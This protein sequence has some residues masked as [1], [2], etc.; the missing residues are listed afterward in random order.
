MTLAN[1]ETNL[2]HLGNL[3]PAKGSNRSTKRRG[4]GI[5]SGTGKTGGRGH[6]GQRARKS[7]GVRFGFEGGQTPLYRRL[8]KR[9]FTNTFAKKWSIVNLTDLAR[10]QGDVDAISL[11]K[12]GLIREKG[13]PIKILG[14]GQLDKPLKISVHACSEAARLLIEKVGGKIDIIALPSGNVSPRN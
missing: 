13:L 5:G 14:K 12:A 9:G 10:C 6:K 11:K 7:G 2:L 8:P 4:R 1:Q 3:H